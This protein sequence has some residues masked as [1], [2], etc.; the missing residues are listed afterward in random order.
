MR[1]SFPSLAIVI[2]HLLSLHL[3]SQQDKEFAVRTQSCLNV[4]EQC[5]HNHVTEETYIRTQRPQPHS[6]GVCPVNNRKDSLCVVVNAAWA[7]LFMTTLDCCFWKR[8]LW[9]LQDCFNCVGII[10]VQ[11]KW[12]LMIYNTVYCMSMLYCKY[13]EARSSGPIT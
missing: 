9:F 12:F 5:G 2:I 4:G 1:R 8:D 13:R 3:I 11:F 7:R 6:A 10:F